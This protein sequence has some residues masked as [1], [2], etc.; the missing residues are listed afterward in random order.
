MEDVVAFLHVDLQGEGEPGGRA[1]DVAG[2]DPHLD[3]QLDVER[4]G[5][6]NADGG[7][8]GLLGRCGGRADRDHELFLPSEEGVK[9]TTSPTWYLLIAV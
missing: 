7:T 8:V 6:E 1:A 2:V 9:R 3:W 4:R 5:Q